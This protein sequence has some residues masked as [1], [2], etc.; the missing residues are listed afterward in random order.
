M[1]VIKEEQNDAVELA[2]KSLRAGKVI[3]FATDTVYGIAA[4]AS[5]EAAVEGL[6]ELKKRD[7]KNPI[8]IFVKD[9]ASA[10]KIFYFDSLAQEIAEKFLPGKLTMVLKTNSESAS[11]LAPN[12]NQNDDGFLGFRIVDKK[13]I[14]ELLEKFNGILAV[15]SANLSSQKPSLDALQVTEYF[16]NS[17]LDLLIDGGLSKQKTASTVIKIYDKKMQ[18]LRQGSLNLSAYENRF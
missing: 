14:A 17:K 12:L 13:F 5:N 18:I 11:L 7:K 2:V 15:T 8:A 6:Y 1:Q 9:L 10:K 3:S 4:D 16:S